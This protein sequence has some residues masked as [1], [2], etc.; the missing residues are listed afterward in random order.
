MR[1]HRLALKDPYA[2]V[3][4]VSG[5]FMSTKNPTGLTPK[6]ILLISTTIELMRN[7]GINVL[8][9]GIRKELM[10]RLNLTS[11]NLYNTVWIL[12]TKNAITSD[13]MLNPIF[14]I[15]VS[16]TVEFPE[17]EPQERD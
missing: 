7:M 13:D 17:D 14:R 6:E 8:T 16:L 12:K 9:R 5:V 2:Y 11:R 3:V 1:R 4:A 10:K 15:P